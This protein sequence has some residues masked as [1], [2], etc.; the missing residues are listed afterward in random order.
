MVRSEVKAGNYIL[1]HLCLWGIDVKIRREKRRGL[2][3]ESLEGLPRHGWGREN[4]ELR[5]L[6]RWKKREG[7]VLQEPRILQ[8][9]LQG[10]WARQQ[11][12]E[13]HRAWSLTTHAWVWP[14]SGDWDSSYRCQRGEW[15]MRRKAWR[16]G[17]KGGEGGVRERD[18]E[19]ERERNGWQKMPLFG[20]CNK[21]S[22]SFGKANI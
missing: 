10:C 5:H 1:N 4:E 17:R 3:A 7:A 19:G 20:S 2:R 9:H 6:V 11:G 8:A 21:T 14:L 22:I 13:N 12:G 16:W 18:K 15:K